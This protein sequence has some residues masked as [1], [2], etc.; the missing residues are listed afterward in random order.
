M[1]A[2]TI[3]MLC[4]GLDVVSLLSNALNMAYLFFI[5]NFF[6]FS[7]PYYSMVY[8]EFDDRRGGSG[9]VIL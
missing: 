7:L 2:M 8:L 1:M 5:S 9:G 3:M 6:S 4:F